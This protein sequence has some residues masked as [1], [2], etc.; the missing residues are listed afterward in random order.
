MRTPGI[1][2]V[3][4]EL[5][6]CSFLASGRKR[7]CFIMIAIVVYSKETMRIW[8]R[9]N[10]RHAV[11]VNPCGSLTSTYSFLSPHFSFFLFCFSPIS[12]HLSH[13]TLHLRQ[14]PFTTL[15]FVSISTSA[16]TL[17]YKSE[18]NFTLFSP[19]LTLPISLHP[20]F[21]PNP[22]YSLHSVPY[23]YPAT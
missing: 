9:Y 2:F 17:L 23:T 8:K 10:G 21:T 1:G 3:L 22:P 4:Q 18:A 19:P 5:L 13:V 16:F 12:Y 11:I 20:L 6:K 14:C 15:C 7:P